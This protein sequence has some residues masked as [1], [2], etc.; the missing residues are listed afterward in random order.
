MTSGTGARSIEEGILGGGDRDLQKL[1]AQGLVP[2]PPDRL[3][4]LLVELATAE[5]AEL[6]SMA[7]QSLEEVDPR[8]VAPVLANDPNAR[9]VEYFALHSEHPV[10]LETIVR[11]ADVPLSILLEL[12]PR[13]PGGVQE[14]LILRQDAILQEPGILDALESNPELER[15]V[16]RRVGEYRQHLFP[17]ESPTVEVPVD[18][19]EE[20]EVASPHE[21]AEAIQAA[22][23]E[24]VEGEIDDQ[25]G[26]AEGQIRTLPIPV[27]LQL[28]RGAGKTLRDMLIRDSN[29]QVAK[30]VLKFNTFSDGEVERI[31]KMRTIVEDVLEAIGRSR[32]WMRKYP[33]S[34]ALVKNPRTPIPIAV[35][36][37]PRMAVRDLRILRRDR[38]V[39]EAVRTLANRLFLLKVQ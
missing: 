37:V 24:P 23:L 9:V 30:S 18:E 36:I 27:R 25:T 19:R 32:R 13:L 1:A 2:L 39:S 38:N 33:I 4:P 31:A 17:A 8:L 34:L 26:L 22:F 14:V 7:S 15:S 3:I 11:L 28:S 16:S 12:A 35:G 20:E 21:I 6:A 29:P 10:I 5:D